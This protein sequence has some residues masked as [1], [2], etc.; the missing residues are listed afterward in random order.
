MDA[1]FLASIREQRKINTEKKLIFIEGLQS[2]IWKE[3][4]LSTLVTMT[5]G[6]PE[7]KLE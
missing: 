7:H 6:R 2:V 4:A 1:I 3:V 5:T